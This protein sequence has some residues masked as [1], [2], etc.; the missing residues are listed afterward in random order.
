MNK[1]YTGH[2]HVYRGDG[3]MEVDWFSYVCAH[4]GNGTSGAVLAK[5]RRHSR[6]VLF[7]ECTGCGCGSII[8]TYEDRLVAQ[9]PAGRFGPDVEGLPD[10]V[11]AAYNEARDCMSVNAYTG[12]ELVC[13]KI[14][15]YA[16]VDKAG[17]KEGDKFE[18]CLDALVNAG[19]ITPPM[20][21]W[22]DVIRK[23]GNAATHEMA[24]PTVER[25]QSTIEFTANML[26]VVYEM[27]HKAKKHLAP[28]PPE[29]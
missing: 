16:A 12:A 19:Y 18:K 3:S 27:E 9:F 24:K 21:P 8:E 4:C 28:S 23:N 5:T 20:R 2:R 15:M 25:A 17:A 7:A 1:N 13:R 10:S 11:V 26:R 14:L 29:S 6:N 22:V